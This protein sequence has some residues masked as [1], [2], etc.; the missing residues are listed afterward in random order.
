MNKNIWCCA[1]GAA[2]CVAV[3]ACDAAHAVTV[4]NLAT[5]A[6]GVRVVH[7]EALANADQVTVNA[8]VNRVRLTRVIAPMRLRFELVDADGRV[9][10]S[11]D[12]IIGPA[13]LPRHNSRDA[14]LAVTLAAAAQP[15][16]QVVV[17]WTKAPAQP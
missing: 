14:R 11:K 3:F 4:T 17:A 5:V 6:N 10:A 2:L 13:Q 8:R 16:D 15:S 1:A 9:R 12:R 7:A